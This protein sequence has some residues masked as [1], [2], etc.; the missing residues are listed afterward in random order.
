[1]SRIFVKIMPEKKL[2]KENY[3]NLPRMIEETCVAEWTHIPVSYTHLDVYKRQEEIGNP[4]Y[5]PAKRKLKEHGI[6]CSG[7][8][9]VQ[10]KR[11][12]YCLLYTSFLGQ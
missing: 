9:A 8:Y 12:D 3:E 5:P 7:K 11:S 1:M 6:D 4:V 2:T 10:L